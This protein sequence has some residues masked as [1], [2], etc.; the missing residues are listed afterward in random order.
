MLIFTHI[1]Y[2]LL[3]LYML[4]LMVRIIDLFITLLNDYIMFLLSFYFTLFIMLPRQTVLMLFGRSLCILFFFF[5]LSLLGI[6]L[7][8]FIKPIQYP[9]FGFCL[10]LSKHCHATLIDRWLLIDAFG[11]LYIGI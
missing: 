7:L 6:L 1:S 4:L 3:Y 9:S 5:L 11:C 10:T 2:K 8:N